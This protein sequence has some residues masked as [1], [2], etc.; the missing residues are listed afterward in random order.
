[1]NHGAISCN[2]E[3]SNVMLQ[4]INESSKRV[5]TFRLEYKDDYEYEF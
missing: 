1:M 3:T 4:S 2:A 5:G